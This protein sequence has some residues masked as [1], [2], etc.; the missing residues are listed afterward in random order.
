MKK[1]PMKKAGQKS[2]LDDAGKMMRIDRHD[3][4]GAISGRPGHIRESIGIVENA[5]LDIFAPGRIIVCGMGWSAVPGDILSAYLFG[6]SHL[7]VTVL[8]HYNFPSIRY[9]DPI[10]FVISYSGNT[11]E[12]LEMAKSALDAKCRVVGITSGGKLAKLCQRRNATLIRVPPGIQ[13]RAAVG[14]LFSTM[15]MVLERLGVCKISGELCDCAD[16][17]DD[18]FPGISPGTPAKNNLSKRI[19]L[20]LQD[21]VPVIYGHGILSPVAKCWQAQ[22]N[23]NSKI[24][25]WSGEFPEMN[26]NE[27]VGWAGSG[28]RKGYTPVLLREENEDR[29]MERRIE[30]TK[31]IAFGR[32]KPVIEVRANGKSR[33]TRMFSA[34]WVGE[35]AS[36]YLAC[37]RG[38]DPSSVDAIES[39]KEEM[40]TYK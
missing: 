29:R 13:P 7:A 11:E 31:K 35:F 23:E 24:L 32:T 18:M 14:Y 36:V 8:R 34:L 30:L 39:L 12:T 38:I 20:T 21:S 15:A 26:H 4:L 5:A 33:V 28:F 40:R 3:M 19:A 25:A 2:V 9:R 22:F 27:I 17:L 6:K 37:L 10:V 1:S 16:E